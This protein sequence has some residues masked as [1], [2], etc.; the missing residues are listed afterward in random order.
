MIPIFL[1]P[2]Q[3]LTN[4]PGMRI[5]DD[6]YQLLIQAPIL[7]QEIHALLFSSESIRY[8]DL[9][10]VVGL[11]RPKRPHTGRGSI[12][13]STMRKMSSEIIRPLTMLLKTGLCHCHGI[14][15]SGNPI[16]SGDVA[17]LG[18]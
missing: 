14:S 16:G 1:F 11:Q 5:P 17:E 7:E 18:M 3:L 2:R 8:I 9:T 12:N 13:H 6:Y 4:V 10:N 15:M